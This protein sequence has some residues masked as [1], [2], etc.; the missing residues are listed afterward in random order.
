[1]T[2]LFI[3]MLTVTLVVPM[4]MVPVIDS[5]WMEF[6]FLEEEGDQE[7]L[8]LLLKQVN[9]WV[10]RHLVCALLAV[11]FVAVLVYAPNQL[12]QPRPLA[13]ITGIYATI[14][15]T[16]A[17]VE[18]LLAQEIYHLIARPLEPVKIKLS[19]KHLNC[20]RLDR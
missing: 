1:M 7:N 6:E 4:I 5:Q 2:T 20:S 17:F 15:I 16:F 11:L 8:Q 13:I 12:D 3:L 18:S 9:W 19:P 14:S 10:M